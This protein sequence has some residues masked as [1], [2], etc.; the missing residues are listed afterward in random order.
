[1][2]CWEV[3]P[4]P[5]KEQSRLLAAC[6]FLSWLP[7]SADTPAEWRTANTQAPIHHDIIALSSITWL[8]RNQFLLLPRGNLP[9]FEWLPHMVHKNIMLAFFACD[10]RV[11]FSV[12]CLNC[13]WGQS[14]L[15][16][17]QQ[18]FV[19]SFCGFVYPTLFPTLII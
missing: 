12:F 1:M 9:Q 11:L 10:S 18:V 13:R 14:D 8:T 16:H 7:P 6:S 4:S 15:L 2:A 17:H 5:R 3:I 19:Q